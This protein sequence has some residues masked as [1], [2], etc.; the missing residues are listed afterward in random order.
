MKKHW[1]ILLVIFCIILMLGFFWYGMTSHERDANVDSTKSMLEKLMTVTLKMPDNCQ[2]VKTWEMDEWFD[3][4]PINKEEWMNIDCKLPDKD[5]MQEEFKWI[6][7]DIDWSFQPGVLTDEEKKYLYCIS[8]GIEYSYKNMPNNQNDF[9]LPNDS[10]FNEPCI[11]IS[12]HEYILQ[13]PK[14]LRN[15]LKI[16]EKPCYYLKNTPV[17]QY[18]R[19][20][21]YCDSFGKWP[22]RDE[23]TCIIIRIVDSEVNLRQ[24]IVVPRKD[25]NHL[26]NLK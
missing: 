12:F 23:K 16:A 22:Y 8:P 26:F 10:M 18:Y 20:E 5:R 9:L 19:K 3:L 2:P 1:P 14:I 4:E 13:Y 11:I 17:E 15:I 24:Q 6:K 25:N 21:L 7:R